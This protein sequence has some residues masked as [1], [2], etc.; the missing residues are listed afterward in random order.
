MAYIQIASISD[1]VEYNVVIRNKRNKKYKIRIA[2]L[3]FVEHRYYK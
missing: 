2:K 1:D 3:P